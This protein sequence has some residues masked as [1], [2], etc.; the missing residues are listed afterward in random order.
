MWTTEVLFDG[1]DMMYV[2][3][4]WRRFCRIHE[5]M[6]GHFLVFNYD[7]EHT[8]TVMIF[9]ETMCRLHYTPAS[10]AN[11]SSSSSSDE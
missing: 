4:G 1:T 10:L 11:A 8:L 2:A 3:S 5:I 6:D 7:G 9:E